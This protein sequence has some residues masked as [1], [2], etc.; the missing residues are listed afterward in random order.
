[1]EKKGAK[2]LSY[3]TDTSQILCFTVREAGSFQ[4]HDPTTEDNLPY[5]QR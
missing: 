4:S 3:D 5:R 1:M 2:G